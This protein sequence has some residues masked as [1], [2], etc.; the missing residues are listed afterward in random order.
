MKNKASLVLLEQLWMILIFA[1]AAAICLLVFVKADAISRQT[2]KK[3]QAVIL[4]QRSAEAMK[5]ARGDWET[6]S[7]LLTGAD[8]LYLKIT[9]ED[10][11]SP[12]LAKAKI[13]VYDENGME[14][15]SLVTGWQEVVP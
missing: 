3:D 7:E 15:Y 11:P 9:Q 12:T 4:A 13:C 8:G 5:A 6:V 10:S 14:L 1:I 2:A